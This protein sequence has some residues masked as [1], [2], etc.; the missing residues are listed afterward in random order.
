[1]TLNSQHFILIELIN[2]YAVALYIN[3]N[4]T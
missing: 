3:T 4:C 1:M 2:K